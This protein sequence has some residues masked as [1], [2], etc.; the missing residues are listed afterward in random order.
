[1]I[2]AGNRILSSL[3]NPAG[4]AIVYKSAINLLIKFLDYQMMNDAISE[5][6]SKDLSLH[7]S[8]Y[9]ERN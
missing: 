4:I 8:A 2:N 9:Y 7:R 5:V 3:A 6:R 1:M